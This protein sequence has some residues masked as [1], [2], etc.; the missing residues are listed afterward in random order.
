MVG[1]IITA[2]SGLVGV[3]VGQWII[4]K[5][6]QKRVLME[7]VSR[8]IK[9]SHD[10]MDAWMFHYHLRQTH[11]GGSDN[12]QDMFSAF[13]D[14]HSYRSQLKADMAIVG[15]MFRGKSQELL[16]SVLA[17]YSYGIPE[18]VSTPYEEMESELDGKVAVVIDHALAI[19]ME[20]DEPI[21]HRIFGRRSYVRTRQE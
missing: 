16:R 15:M 3:F 12:T 20:F 8:L 5:R 9:N 19:Y 21:W 13:K 6:E 2:L 18:S 4:Q 11:G 17:L 7:A 10:Y 14:M 1:P